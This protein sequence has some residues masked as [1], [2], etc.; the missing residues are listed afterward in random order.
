MVQ[1]VPY[2]ADTVSAN[3]A[4]YNFDGQGNSVKPSTNIRDDGRVSVRQL[5]TASARGDALHKELHGR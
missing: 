2:S 1:E 3:L 4:R 5:I